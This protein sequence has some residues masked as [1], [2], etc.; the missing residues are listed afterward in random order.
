KSL[1]LEKEYLKNRFKEKK[2]R[3]INLKKNN[4]LD[5]KIKLADKYID[6]TKQREIF[7]NQATQFKQW[8]NYIAGLVLTQEGKKIFTPTDVKVILRGRLIPDYYDEP[9]FKEGSLLTQD[10]EIKSKY[11][12]GYP[13]LKRINRGRYKFIGFVCGRKKLTKSAMRKPT[14]KRQKNENKKDN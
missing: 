2:E 13:S 8:A 7:L 9:G 14:V 11:H 4:A 5:I 10:V 6:N 3:K 1:K 12:E